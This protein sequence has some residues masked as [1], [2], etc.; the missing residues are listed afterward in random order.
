MVVEG[1][2]KVL[3]REG[4]RDAKV[5]V[6]SDMMTVDEMK[7]LRDRYTSLKISPRDE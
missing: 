1:G 5:Q 4:K 2:G 7:W 3:E 6:V